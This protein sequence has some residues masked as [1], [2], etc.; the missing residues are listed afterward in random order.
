MLSLSLWVLLTLSLLTLSLLGA[1]DTFTFDAFTLHSFSENITFQ[2]SKIL[3]N[4]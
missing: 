1:F 3:N 4:Y 2:T